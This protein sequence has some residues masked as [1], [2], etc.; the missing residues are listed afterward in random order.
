MKLT[1]MFKLDLKK[2]T[3]TAFRTP[4]QNGLMQNVNI[5]CTE[6]EHLYVFYAPKL[7]LE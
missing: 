5:V 6:N 3:F 2:M 4:V 1:M 7:K